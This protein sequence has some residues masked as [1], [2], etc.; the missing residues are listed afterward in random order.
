M[1]TDY[2]TAYNSLDYDAFVQKVDSAKNVENQK[3]ADEFIESYKT[4]L[5]EKTTY[6]EVNELL[7]AYTD[8]KENLSGSVKLLINDSV[9]LKQFR[10]KLAKLG[11]PTETQQFNFDGIDTQE[12]LDEELTNRIKSLDSTNTFS[13]NGDGI[14]TYKKNAHATGGFVFENEA[15]AT[16]EPQT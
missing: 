14:V 6:S 12:E 15:D 8:A 4:Q 9:L 5:A 2:N 11:E 10:N 16:V 7:A 1:L 13:L 3:T